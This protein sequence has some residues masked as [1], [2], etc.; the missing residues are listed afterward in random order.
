MNKPPQAKECY[1]CRRIIIIITGKQKLIEIRFFGDNTIHKAAISN[2]FEFE[3]SA[4]III[5]NLKKNKTPLYRRSIVEAESL[6]G[7]PR[8]MSLTNRVKI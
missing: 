4:E 3:E 6:L 8:E 7:I 1:W 2:F 5:A